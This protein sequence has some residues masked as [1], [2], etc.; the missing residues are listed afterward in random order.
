MMQ[1]LTHLLQ[2]D[3]ISGCL[4]HTS[5]SMNRLLY[6]DVLPSACKAHSRAADYIL[7]VNMEECGRRIGNV[8]EVHEFS[9]GGH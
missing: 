3:I 7:F 1:S 8:P 4:A 2:R 5:R 9:T 6:S